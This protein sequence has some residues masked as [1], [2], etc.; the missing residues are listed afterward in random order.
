MQA[1]FDTSDLIQ[2]GTKIAIGLALAIAGFVFGIVSTVVA[3]N[4]LYALGVPVDTSPS[5]QIALTVVMFQGV[6]FGSVALVYLKL[7]GL[8]LDFIKARFPTL[9]DLAWAVGGFISFVVLIMVIGLIL[10]FLGIE[11]ASNQIEEIGKRNPEIFLL[12]I[13]FS[14]LL[15]GPGEEL[16]F[17]GVIQGTLREFFKPISGIVLASLI[18]AVGHWEALGGGFQQRLVYIG[19]V[20]V[21]SLILGTV[22]E[23]TENLVV[24]ALIHGAYNAL[25]FYAMYVLYSAEPGS[26]AFIL[27]F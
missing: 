20:F 7:R 12:M 3:A 8:G 6:S 11:S 19:V 23:K 14:F 17:R 9:R 4:V 21:L 10:S 27:P 22:Y 1:H 5:I 2:G 15:I 13:P 25:L 16:L 24:P 18:F 26:T